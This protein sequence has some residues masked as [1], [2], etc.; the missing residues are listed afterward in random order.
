MLLAPDY[1]NYQPV[2]LGRFHCWFDF[3]SREEQQFGEV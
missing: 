2:G 3:V 1:Y